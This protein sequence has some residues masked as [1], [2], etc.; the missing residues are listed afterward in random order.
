MHNRRL[1]LK[2]KLGNM[3]NWGTM[4]T[5]ILITDESNFLD[6]KK[7]TYLDGYYKKE[8]TRY[9]RNNPKKWGLLLGV[10]FHRVCPQHQVNVY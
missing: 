9:T 7:K 8:I 10:C 4:L 3:D 2:K 1:L 5:V 6:L